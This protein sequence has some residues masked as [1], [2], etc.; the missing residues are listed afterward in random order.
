MAGQLTILYYDKLRMRINVYYD[1][2]EI[3]Y[4][5]IN[6]IHLIHIRKAFI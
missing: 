1:S 2:K 3:K 6:K 5:M 4:A